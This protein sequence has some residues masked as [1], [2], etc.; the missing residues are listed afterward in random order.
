MSIKTRQRAAVIVLLGVLA[1]GLMIHFM[2]SPE[3]EYQGKRLSAW[4][5]EFDHWEGDTNAPVVLAMRAFGPQAVPS[6]VE[7]CLA[8]DSVLKQK[9]SV[10]FEKHATLLEHRSTTA[11]ERWNRAQLALRVMGHDARAA[12][13]A[14]VAA[15]TNEDAFV[16][17]RAVSAL[18]WIG[19]EA[20]NCLPALIARQDDQAVRGNLMHALELIGRRPDLCVPVLMKALDD[21]D[22]I[23]RQNAVHSLGAF[24]GRASAAIPALTKA[25]TDKATAR[26][27]SD[28]LRKIQSDESATNQSL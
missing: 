16:R 18:G 17:M 6:L 11:P 14:F 7:M 12:L 23:V 20:E 10:E 8:N 24:R 19:P 9:V 21:A 1:A 28:A 25:L 3:P 22:P 5:T 15:L 4:L 26:R 27:A 2:R 13:P